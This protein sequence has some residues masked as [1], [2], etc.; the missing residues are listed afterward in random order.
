MKTGV[1]QSVATIVVA[2]VA[3][4]LVVIRVAMIV[5]ARAAVANVVL[6]VIR[7]VMKT[8]AVQAVATT[9]VAHEVATT[10]VA[11]EVAMVPVI[12]LGLRTAS[13]NRAKATRPG[14]LGKNGGPTAIR[15]T[16]PF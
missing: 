16:T 14:F 6:V 10:V 15:L 8:G 13:V 11:H 4:A 5:V 1:V 7:A 3:V 12:G 2:R 9:A